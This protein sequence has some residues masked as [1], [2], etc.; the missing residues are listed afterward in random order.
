MHEARVVPSLVGVFLA[1][2]AMTTVTALGL[3]VAQ[4][5]GERMGGRP[6]TIGVTADDP[7]TGMPPDPEGWDAAVADLTERYRI[8]ATASIAYEETRFR[9][10]GGTRSVRTTGVSPSYGELHRIEPIEGRWLRE[11]TGSAWL[12]P[13]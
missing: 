2:F 5:Q 11:G 3:L 9:L 4:V 10:T 8:T 13:S 6:A 7:Q 1:A 12:R